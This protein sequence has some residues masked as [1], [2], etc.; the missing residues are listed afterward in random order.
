MN[1]MGHSRHDRFGS[2]CAGYRTRRVVES[3]SAGSQIGCRSAH[4]PVM[5]N[6]VRLQV[7]RV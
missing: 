7:E 5:L 1:Q 4:S 6:P 2:F 3:A